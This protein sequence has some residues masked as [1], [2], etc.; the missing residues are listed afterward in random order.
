[1]SLPLLKSLP[2]APPAKILQKGQAVGDSDDLRRILA[3]PRRERPSDEQI[4]EWARDFKEELGVVNPACECRTKYRR[5]CCDQLKPVQ[6][7]CMRRL[8]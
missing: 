1:M 6:G 4:A 7:R 2:A 8:P 5:P 3:L